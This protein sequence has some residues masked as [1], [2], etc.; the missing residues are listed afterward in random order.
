M[1]NMFFLVIGLCILLTTTIF[2]S[3]CKPIGTAPEI[4]N[5]I[6]SIIA[7]DEGKHEIFTVSA[8]DK[9]SEDYFAP[10]KTETV[11][12]DYVE[13]HVFRGYLGGPLHVSSVDNEILLRVSYT[14]ESSG[15]DLYLFLIPMDNIPNNTVFNI[16][17]DLFPEWDMPENHY[18]VANNFVETYLKDETKRRNTMQTLYENNYYGIR[19][20][21]LS[22]ESVTI[23]FKEAT[24]G[25][26]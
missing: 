17:Q 2:F 13:K 20:M 6:V 16:L 25:Y 14:A 8:P 24:G 12:T 10:L 18:D 9:N 15:H 5:Y 21:T 26:D 19:K 22:D 3:C 1:K 4:V 7:V 11:T 23:T